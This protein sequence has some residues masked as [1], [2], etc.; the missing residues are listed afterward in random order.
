LYGQS[1]LLDRIGAGTLTSMPP[2]LSI[3]LLKLRKSTIITWLISSPVRLSIVR[4][5]SP[6]PPSW[7]AELIRSSPCPGI[8]TRRSRGIERYTSRCRLGSVRRTMI[9]SEWFR[10]ARRSVFSWSRPSRSIVV[11]FESSSPFWF[12]STGGTDLSSRA[13][14]FWTPWRN[15]R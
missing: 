12:A 8:G 15:D 2:M 3:R 13:F 1:N 11:G 5:V 4:T 10:L 9:E 14:A 6:A 7:N